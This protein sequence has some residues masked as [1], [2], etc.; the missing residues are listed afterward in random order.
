M[1]HCHERQRQRYKRNKGY[2]A[3]IQNIDMKFVL[4]TW[5]SKIMHIL[6]QEVA[7]LCSWCPQESRINKI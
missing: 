4:V 3:F 5:E 7:K 1:Q 6:N 2:I